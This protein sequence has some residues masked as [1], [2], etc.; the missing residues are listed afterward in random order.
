MSETSRARY[1]LMGLVL[2]CYPSALVLA[3]AVGLKIDPMEFIK[4]SAFALAV[5]AVFSPI[6]SWRKIPSLRSVVEA[7]GFGMLMTG[8]IIVMAYVAAMANQPLQDQRLIAMDQN[9]GID[10]HAL[11]AFIDAHAML[12]QTLWIAYRTFGMQLILLPVVLGV[13]GQSARA[14][15]MMAAYGLICIFANI[16]SIWYPALGTYTA[17]SIDIHQFKNIDGSLGVDFPAQLLAVRNDPNFVLDRGH[18][19]G[20]ISFPSVHAAVAIL[21]AW[22]AW[23]MKLFRWPVLILNVLMLSSAVP[24]GAHYV[25]DLISGIGVAGFVVALVLCVTRPYAMAKEHAMASDPII[26]EQS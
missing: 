25:V 8:P 23:P 18:V 19:S 21:C 12:A 1:F 9:L 11:I 5:V 24:E 15:Q 22:A 16:I 17:L 4:F 13:S 26:L 10:W 3:R 20:I 2:A 14:Y 6:C 7:I